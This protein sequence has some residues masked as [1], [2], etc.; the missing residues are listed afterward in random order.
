MEMSLRRTDAALLTKRGRVVGIVTDHDLTRYVDQHGQICARCWQ[1]VERN[2]NGMYSVC[3]PFPCPSINLLYSCGMGMATISSGLG[4][5]FEREFCTMTLCR[6]AL[7]V[8]ALIVLCAY[9]TIKLLYCLVVC[10]CCCLDLSCLFLSSLCR[11]GLVV[12]SH[13]SPSALFFSFLVTAALCVHACF[14][15]TLLFARPDRSSY[16]HTHAR[17]TANPTRVVNT[18]GVMRC[19]LIWFDFP[20]QSFLMARYD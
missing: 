11:G 18:C 14:A 4:G 3:L 8:V 15:H 10:C 1:S 5:A 19:S 6:F 17:T 2:K 7:V 13:R 12:V 9:C 16:A 20:R